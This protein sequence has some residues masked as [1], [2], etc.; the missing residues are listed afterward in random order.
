[1]AVRHFEQ[2]QPRAVVH[3]G[4]PGTT[5]GEPVLTSE[6]TECRGPLGARR[7]LGGPALQEDVADT[8]FAEGRGVAVDAGMGG[9]QPIDP[10]G[11]RVLPFS[12]AYSG[13]VADP[14]VV[15]PHGAAV[16]Q[17]CGGIEYDDSVSVGTPVQAA[18]GAPGQHQHATGARIRV[19]EALDPAPLA[20]VVDGFEPAGRAPQ[21]AGQQSD[22]G[23]REQCA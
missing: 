8:E 9:V 15:V 16:E 20:R 7:R 19:D 18:I 4:E 13:A 12:D 3:G 22:R 1:M 23:Q 11:E 5:R 6:R 2:E 21:Q 10:A 14:E 17:L